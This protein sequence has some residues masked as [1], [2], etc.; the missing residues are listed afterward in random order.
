[1]AAKIAIASK[2]NP[3]MKFLQYLVQIGFPI[4]IVDD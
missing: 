4:N 3:E 1:L 2:D